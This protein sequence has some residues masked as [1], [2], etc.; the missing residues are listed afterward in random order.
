[1]PTWDRVRRG[2]GQFDNVEDRV[3]QLHGHGQDQAVGVRTDASFHWEGPESV[4]R[5]FLR[6]SG[7]TNV[8]RVEVDLVAWGEYRSRGAS[9]VIVVRHLV[10]CLS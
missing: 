9:S 2:G 7:R 6:W 3:K 1:V 10:L 8:G 4:M 5:Q